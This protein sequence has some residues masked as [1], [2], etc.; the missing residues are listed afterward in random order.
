MDGKAGAEDLVRKLL[1]DPVL[2][3]SLASTPKPAALNA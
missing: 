1:A 2:M 3:Q